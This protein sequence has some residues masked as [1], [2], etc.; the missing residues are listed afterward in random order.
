[1][2]FFGVREKNLGFYALYEALLYQ[3]VL[4]PNKNM[5]AEPFLD[6]HRQYLTH[7]FEQYSLLSINC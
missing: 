6:P 7:A 5:K 2:L 4:E 3:R 1:M